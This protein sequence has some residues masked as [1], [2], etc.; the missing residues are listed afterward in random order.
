MHSV[1][2]AFLF[3]TAAL[4]LSQCGSTRTFLETDVV[5]DTQ[6]T[7]GE[8]KDYPEYDDSL[9]GLCYAFTNTVATN[10]FGHIGHYFPNAEV[11]R[12]LSPKETGGM[13]DEDIEK[14]LLAPLRERLEA[15]V[16]NLRRDA[17]KKGLEYSHIAMIREELQPRENESMPVDVV[18]ILL[19]SDRITGTV[20][21]TFSEIDGKF[22]IFEVL[23]TTDI[24]N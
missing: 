18:T 19:G 10:D 21:V 12:Q 4:L 16:E 7:F 2:P 15:N 5:A 9:F 14:N 24:F 6:E 1:R 23:F 11:A 8:D 13:T 17:E 22:Y 3:L 20:P